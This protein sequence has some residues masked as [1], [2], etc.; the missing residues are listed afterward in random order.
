MRHLAKLKKNTLLMKQKIFFL[1]SFNN[2]SP[3]MFKVA[4]LFFDKKWIDYK[5]R[6]EKDQ[7][8]SAIHVFHQSILI[9]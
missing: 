3:E 7:E 6:D 4:K 8:L 9:F 2:F 5:I 1:E